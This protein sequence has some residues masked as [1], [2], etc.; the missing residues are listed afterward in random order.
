MVSPEPRNSV[1][2]VSP[3]LHEIGMVS[4]E[5][6]GTP[7]VPGTPGAASCSSRSRE[8]PRSANALA[9]ASS[10][11]D[12]IGVSGDD[13]AAVASGD[14]TPDSRVNAVREKA[15]ASIHQYGID[16]AIVVA[17]RLEHSVLDDSSPE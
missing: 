10:Q 13:F 9:I 7:G 15:H 6:L 17:A 1:G 2:M 11:N 14:C 8:S 4:P 12:S 16:S 3:E 5:L